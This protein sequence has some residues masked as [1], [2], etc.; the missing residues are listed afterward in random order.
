MTNSTEQTN[1]TAAVRNS[2][3]PPQLRHRTAHHLHRDGGAAVAEIKNEDFEI[4]VILEGN[5]ETT[6]A[7]CHIRTSYLPQEIL[8]GYRF[9][10]IYPK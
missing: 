9:V 4:V 1:C 8:F 5:I 3:S 7:S 2:A 10:P 6:G